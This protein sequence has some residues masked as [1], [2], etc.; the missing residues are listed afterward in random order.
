M[1]LEADNLCKRQSKGEEGGAAKDDVGVEVYEDEGGRQASVS[2]SAI[3]AERM[4]AACCSV[5]PCAAITC[6]R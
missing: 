3:A 1:K 4:I 2:S 6:M 5:K